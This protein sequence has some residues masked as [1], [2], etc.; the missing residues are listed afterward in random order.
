M[1]Y[2]CPH[3]GKEINPGKML[4]GV[5]TAKREAAW[6]ANGERLR[7]MYANAR[8][9]GEEPEAA[10][11]RVERGAMGPSKTQGIA[12]IAPKGSFSKDD[13]RAMLED[14]RGM[15]PAALGGVA[16]DAGPHAPFDFM[17][18]EGNPHR[19]RAYGKQLKVC[20]LREGVEEPIR[21]VRDG[22]LET[23]WQRRTNK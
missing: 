18:E 8:A 23:L 16:M 13:L 17:D 9:V 15:F 7:R 11:I 5:R 12:G 3:C 1:E 19:V 22:E 14:K 4:G 6:K 20:F 21:D 10:A 2:S